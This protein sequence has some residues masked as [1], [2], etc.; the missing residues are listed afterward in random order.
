LQKMNMRLNQSN[1]LPTISAFYQF[2]KP[3]NKNTLA[4]TP[5]N[6]IGLKVSLPIFTSGQRLA[7]LSQA[8]MGYV[9]AQNDTYRVGQGLKLEYTQDRSAFLN[10]IDKF[11]T[12]K[13]NM[14]LAWK[15]YSRTIIKYRQGVGS[16]IELT[17][18]QNQYLQNQAAY[19]NSIVELTSA[20][21][22]F[23]KLLLK[24]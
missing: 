20:K 19:Y 8:K 13:Q 7:Q 15:I 9:K 22:K 1:F 14:D 21:A 3:L 6:T 17:Q 12:T 5:Q 23:E 2:D 16:S 18:N 24:K 11:N 10:A 4:F